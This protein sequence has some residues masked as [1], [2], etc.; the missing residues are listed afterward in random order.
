MI[1][2]HL[3]AH[4]VFLT[5]LDFKL[6]RVF[7]FDTFMTILVWNLYNMLLIKTLVDL[8][9]S[10]SASFC[11]S[12]KFFLFVCLSR[13]STLLQKNTVQSSAC[14][15]N[16]V[17]VQSC[18]SI[19]FGQARWPRLILSVGLFAECFLP[20]LYSGVPAQSTRGGCGASGSN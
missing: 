15:D 12:A 13:P 9:L 16:I 17:Y 6:L 4:K 1:S 7:I 11:T 20:W 14:T 5:R 8:K 10:V 18:F 3:N 2:D 19:T